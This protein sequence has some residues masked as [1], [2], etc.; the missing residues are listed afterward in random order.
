MHWLYH[1]IL[2][3]PDQRRYLA[4][5]GHLPQM[6]KVWELS[7]SGYFLLFTLGAIA[8]G[9]WYPFDL[10]APPDLAYL[11]DSFGNL[12]DPI[13]GERPSQVF[14]IDLP[15]SWSRSDTA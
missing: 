8:G 5:N 3:V 10:S 12:A 11:N 4:V 2:R 13:G 7:I 1:Y 6:P 15:L 14:W 9:P